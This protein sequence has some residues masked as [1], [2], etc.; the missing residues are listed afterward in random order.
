MGMS[1]TIRG[2]A[3]GRPP[4]VAQTCQSL[5][6]VRIGLGKRRF[7][8]G[9]TAGAAANRQT[10]VAIE[11]RNSRRVVAPILHP[12]QRLDHDLARGT[13]T[14]ISDDSAHSQPG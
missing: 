1:V 7:K 4:G 10:S 6:R 3:V 5:Q 9:E 11:Y 12:A 8:V 13:M 14:D 2:P